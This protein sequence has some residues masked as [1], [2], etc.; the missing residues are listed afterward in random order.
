MNAIEKKLY[1]AIER[2][3]LECFKLTKETV[4]NFHQW[5]IK[6]DWSYNVSTST[7]SKDGDPISFDD[8]FDLFIK[9]TYG[10]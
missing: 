2:Q 5:S 10:E 7:Y 3:A 1:E 9:E 4:Y 6:S 8:L